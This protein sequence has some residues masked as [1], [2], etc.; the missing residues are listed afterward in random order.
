MS[1][2]ACARPCR[3]SRCSTACSRPMK[4]RPHR[5]PSAPLRGRP[6]ACRPTSSGGSC[7][8]SLA[9]ILTARIAA[10]SRPPASRRSRATDCPAVF[11]FANCS[12]PRSSRDN[13]F[14]AVAKSED[15]RFEWLCRLDGQQLPDALYAVGV[16]GDLF[17]LGAVFLGLHVPAQRHDVALDVDVDTA[18][19]EL[20]FADELRANLRV[21][22]RVINAV[23]D[24][25]V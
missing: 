2:D 23:A 9:A 5:R 24:R 3:S 1:F 18:A 11:G 22:P 15:A 19:R 17:E 20:T 6:N 13:S 7:R 25:F 12:M 16:L 8:A 21:N 4:G 10:A 14:R